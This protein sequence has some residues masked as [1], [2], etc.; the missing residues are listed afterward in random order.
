[1]NVNL[2][3]IPLFYGCDKKGPEAAPDLLR[4]NGIES[5]ISKH[6][7]KVY[8]LGNLYVKPESDDTKFKANSNMKY[9]DSVVD[10][11]TNLAHM[12]YS[13]LESN[14]FPFMLGGDHSLGLG[15]IS[16]ISKHDDKFAVIWMDAH[17]DINTHETSGSGNTHGM[18]LGACMGFGHEKLTNLY[19]K[20]QKVDPKNV[21]ILGA[22]DL[23]EGEMNLIKQN[24][25]NVYSPEDMK[26]KGL[27]ET[28]S[29]IINTLRQNNI[30]RVHL[31]FDMDF[32]DSKF[33][34]GT[35]TPVDSGF[36]IEETKTVLK[37]ILE[38]KLVKSIDFVEFNP[39]LDNNNKTLHLAVDLIDFMFENLNY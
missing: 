32:I 5:I 30:S 16:G 24:N 17:G 2:I 27:K 23:D 4:N 35:G 6:G 28:I 21:F 20:G 34:P 11:N 22:R 18:P 15:S 25:L 13:S 39:N 33:V 12:V 3:G 29:S 9:L 26:S 19:F 38:S 37:E 1:M 36:D 8:D 14:S 10:V 31:S 7:Y